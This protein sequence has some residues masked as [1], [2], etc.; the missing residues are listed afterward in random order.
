MKEKYI[1]SNENIIL[2][3]TDKE[4]VISEIEQQFKNIFDIMKID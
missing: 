3:D 1:A 4:I 2:T